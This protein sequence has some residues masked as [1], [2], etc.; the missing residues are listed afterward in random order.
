MAK[1]QSK[2][3]NIEA[4]QWNHWEDNFDK[5]NSLVES[6]G[7]LLRGGSNGTLLLDTKDGY[8][9]VN[10]NDYILK[11][12]NKI[13]ICAGDIF[14][15][16]YE[17]VEDCMSEWVSVKDRLPSI[18]EQKLEIIAT[19]GA[20]RFYCTYNDEDG[21]H[22]ISGIYDDFADTCYPDITHWM[23]LD[24]LPLPPKPEDK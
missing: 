23:L 22:E 4:V 9:I 20:L 18:E 19:N 17:K 2:L 21:F 24:D 15:K 11:I 6:V 16:T 14:D 3:I 8:K 13:Y 10:K 5:I 7:D 12:N 1:Y